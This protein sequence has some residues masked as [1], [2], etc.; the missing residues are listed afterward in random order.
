MLNVINKIIQYI[1][2]LNEWNEK[3]N[4]ISYKN[5]KELCIHHIIDS[6]SIAEFVH[7]Q[8]Q[9]IGDVG[10]GP[11]LP[12]IV[13]SIL[14]PLN[15]FVL[16]EPKKKY[17]RFLKKTINKLK[18]NN[19]TLLHSKIQEIGG[20]DDYDI[21]LNRAVSSIDYFCNLKNLHRRNLIIFYKGTNIMN[22]LELDDFERFK[23]VFI[24][25][26]KLLENYNM[27]HYIMGLKKRDYIVSRETI[28]AKE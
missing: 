9:R 6:L 17:F 3:F 20:L 25:K 24:K 1:E 19:I 23:I 7:F 21:I 8:R 16:I 13:L 27:N 14:F 5:I 15:K 22:E 10:T 2:I 12:G 18:L 11:G 28:I 26:I 4:L